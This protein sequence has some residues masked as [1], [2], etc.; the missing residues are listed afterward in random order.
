MDGWVWVKIKVEG[1]WSKLELLLP[2]LTSN[3]YKIF[4][5]NYFLQIL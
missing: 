2:N 3:P 1:S 5:Q 4:I